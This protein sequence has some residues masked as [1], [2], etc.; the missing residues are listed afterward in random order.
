MS[1][2]GEYRR[3]HRGP[4]RIVRY[5]WTPPERPKRLPVW[6]PQAKELLEQGHSL[7]SVGAKVG[8][9]SQRVAQIAIKAESFGETVRRKRQNPPGPRPCAQCGTVFRSHS[10]KAVYCS[11]QCAGR[12]RSE[13]MLPAETIRS[14]FELRDAGKSY[15]EIA[16][17]L[18]IAP[19]RSWQFRQTR[20]RHYVHAWAR[21]AGLEVPGKPIKPRP[22]RSRRKV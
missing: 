17:I 2:T 9:S 21:R 13:R 12:A 15:R 7:K 8:V 5:G 6:W 11:R 4:L 14:A 1:S 3:T 16:D 18:D 20:A 22:A 19:D 10:K